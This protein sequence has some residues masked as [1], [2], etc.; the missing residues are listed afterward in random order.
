[1]R[2][3]HHYTII[4]HTIYDHYECEEPNKEEILFQ[5]NKRAIAELYVAEHSYLEEYDSDWF[6]KFLELRKDY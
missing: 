5:T 3:R 1:M 6:Y 2:G 4:L